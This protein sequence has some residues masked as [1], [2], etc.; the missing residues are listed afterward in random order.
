MMMNLELL[1]LTNV[2]ILSR[3]G[4]FSFAKNCNFL[5]KLTLFRNV[6]SDSEQKP[7]LNKGKTAGRYQF[8]T[9]QTGIGLMGMKII[10]FTVGGGLFPHALIN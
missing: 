9:N 6:C 8:D 4:H 7:C 1:V 5:T 10:S 2:D 3:S